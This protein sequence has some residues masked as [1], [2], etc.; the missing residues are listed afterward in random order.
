MRGVPALCFLTACMVTLC[1][2]QCAI[3]QNGRMASHVRAEWLPSFRA[4]FWI[5]PHKIQGVLCSPPPSLISL[6]VS[7]DVKHHAYLLTYQLFP[8]PPFSPS[9][10]SLEI[11][12]DVEHHVYLLLS[13]LRVWINLQFDSWAGYSLTV[14]M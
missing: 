9:L 5:G 2:P 8:P 12:V 3:R 4:L 7:V 10:I 1:Y 6:M 11:S 13:L 14:Y